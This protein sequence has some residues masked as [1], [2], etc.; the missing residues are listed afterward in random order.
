MNRRFGIILA[1]AFST[2]VG[3]CASGGGGGPAGGADAEYPEG[4]PP[5]DNEQTTA[6]ALF[7]AQAVAADDAQATALYRRA[8]EQA[9]QGIQADPGNPQPYF[10]AGMASMG[11]DDYVAA[12]TLFARAQEIYPAYEPEID[13]EREQG[14]INAY[15]QGVRAIQAQNFEEA[16]EHFGRA[17]VVFDKRHEAFMNLAWVNTRLDDTEAAI[18]AYRNALAVLRGPKPETL[19]AETSAAWDE[20]LAAASLNLAQVLAQ[21]GQHQ[22][23]ADVLGEYIEEHPDDLSAQV[24]QADLLMRAGREEEAN[25]MFEEL[26]S[27]PDLGAPE[28]FQIGIGFFNGEDYVRAAEAFEQS[29]ELNPHSR[30]AYYNLVQAQ[31]SAVLE[32]ERDTTYDQVELAEQYRDVIEYSNKVLEYDPFNRNI[33]TFQLR[34]Y[35]GLSE[36]SEQS[37]EAQVSGER[38]R[39]VLNQYQSMPF[40]VTNVALSIASQSQTQVNGTLVNLTYDEGRPIRIRFSLLDSNGRAVGSE[41]VTVSAPAQEQAKPFHINIDTSAQPIGWR[42]EQVQ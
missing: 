31:Y 21:V 9:Q 36:I 27:R 13:A 5:S 33:L 3:A 28:Y 42:Y 16:R 24:N 17:G 2:A 14:W 37:G 29:A 26:L 12:D 41:E 20:D 18:D 4:T 10:Q 25:A 39:E 40:E 7:L 38:V 32:A 11:V 23:A 1:L 6:A 8:L 22:E 35:R 19:D 30:D 15:N 34:A